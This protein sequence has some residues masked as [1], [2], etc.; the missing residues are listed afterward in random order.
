MPDNGP[1]RPGAGP[2]QL[3]VIR[4][5]LLGPVIL[6]G[7]YVAVTV[8]RNP[9]QAPE[10]ARPL[11]YVNLAYLVGAAL[12]LLYFQR[13][14]AAERD[15]ARRTTFNIVAWAI[16]ESTALFGAVHYLLVGSPIPYL[17]GLGMMLA[18]FVLVPIRD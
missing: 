3:R 15:P 16:G 14:H 5:A 1:R 12:G 18:S 6:F 10:L 9:P 17:V 2:T 8:S 11:L 4:M 7:A 13:R